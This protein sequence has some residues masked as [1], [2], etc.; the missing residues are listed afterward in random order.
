MFKTHLG[1]FPCL[2]G[3]LSVPLARGFFVNVPTSQW[4]LLRQC[5]DVILITNPGIGLSAVGSYICFFSVETLTG[6]TPT[7]GPTEPKQTQ[8]FPTVIQRP[9]S[10][11]KNHPTNWN[12]LERAFSNLQR[13]CDKLEQPS[14][15]LQQ[16]VPT[17]VS[18]LGCA[19]HH[20]PDMPYSHP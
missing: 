19:V 9:R 11:K 2:L 17:W 3:I 13:P 16:I 14:P 5:P 10:V 12:K 18:L 15:N 7:E 20:Y 8:S 6:G 4:L 1:L